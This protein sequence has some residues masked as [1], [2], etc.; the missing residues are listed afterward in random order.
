MNYGLNIAILGASGAVGREILKIIHEKKLKY[1]KLRLFATA[2]TAGKT[3][4]ISNNVF[5]IEKTDLSAFSDIDICLASAGSNASKYWV[6]RIVEKGIPVI[7]NCSYWRLHNDV[8]LVVPE[9]NSSDLHDHKGIIGNPN[10]STIQLVQTL[11]PLHKAFT[12]KKTIVSTYQSVSGAGQKGISA[13]KKEIADYP[14]KTSSYFTEP[15]ACN[16]IPVI[17]DMLDNGY[18]SEEMKLQNETRKI[19]HDQNIAITATAVRV[20]VFYGHA[21]SVLIEFSQVVTPQEIRN[22]LHNSKNITVIDD[23]ENQIFP[24]P[25]FS[26][27]T[28][29]TMVGRIRQD[30]LGA[31]WINLWIV[32]NNL[33]KGAA[34]NAVQIAEYLIENGLLCNWK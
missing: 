26:E 27:T 13:L 8:P 15:I 3:S 28:D 33:R 31:N 24:T 23:R 21:E 22:L 7:D 29:H 1:N 9:V 30:L 10:C 6:P 32:S 4:S 20:P 11:A 19:L 18:T 14:K 17:G 25:I 16:L 34:L 5:T 12:I 2:S